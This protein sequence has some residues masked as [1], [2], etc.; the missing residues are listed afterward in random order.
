M[1]QKIEIVG[2]CDET[3]LEVRR[4][5]GPMGGE[6]GED[7]PGLLSGIQRVQPGVAIETGVRMRSSGA[8]G[9]RLG[10]QLE[11]LRG[12]R[13]RGFHG[14]TDGKRGAGGPVF[15]ARSIQEDQRGA[16]ELEQIGARGNPKAGIDSRRAGTTD[17]QVR[18]GDALRKIGERIKGG[19]N[20]SRL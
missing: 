9:M 18:A 1:I 3:L 15:V 13:L 10:R 5:F 6:G 2:Q 12:E 14:T 8:V 16:L 19:E 17:R 11:K 20:Y 7:L 4:V